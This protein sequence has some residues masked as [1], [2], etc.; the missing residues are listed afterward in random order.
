METT[1]DVKIGQVWFDHDNRSREGK[2]TRRDVVIK[3]LTNS[4]VTIENVSTGRQVTVDMK[5]FTRRFSKL[6]ETRVVY[7]KI[8]GFKA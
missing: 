1:S 5:N 7:A 2:K 6:A 8:Q 4:R 3:G